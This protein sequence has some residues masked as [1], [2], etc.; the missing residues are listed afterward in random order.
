[1][2]FS[3][4]IK[5]CIFIFSSEVVVSHSSATSSAKKS[6]RVIDSGYKTERV[7]RTKTKGQGASTLFL[8]NNQQL[9]IRI[10]RYSLTGKTD[11]KIFFDLFSEEK[12]DFVGKYHAYINKDQKSKVHRHQLCRVSFNNNVKYPIIETIELL[13]D[14]ILVGKKSGDL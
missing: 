5:P 1:M 4:K 12:N 7:S 3:G 11:Y 8:A 14:N 13:E 6:L 2:G 9:V 10:Y